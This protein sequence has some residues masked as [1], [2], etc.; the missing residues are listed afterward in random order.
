MCKCECVSGSRCDTILGGLITAR[1]VDAR[2]SLV[3]AG[4][5]AVIAGDIDS[6]R[7]LVLPDFAYITDGVDAGRVL[8]LSRR[9]VVTCGVDACRGLVLSSLAFITGGVDACRGLV[10]PGFAFITGCVDAGRGLVLSG[11][12]RVARG[13]DAGRVLVLAG[14]S[15][16]VS[17]EVAPKEVETLPAV[18]SL[19]TTHH[20][21]PSTCQYLQWVSFVLAVGL[22]PTCRGLF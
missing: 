18:Q 11:D 7:G 22:F 20:P 8:I 19:Q 13:V 5:I 9:A 15:V 4:R 16:Q 1:C 6:L 17:W 21:H 14:K 12:A 3:L 2:R 10:L